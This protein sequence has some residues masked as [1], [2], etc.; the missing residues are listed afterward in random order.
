MKKSQTS[1]NIFPFNHY[2][3]PLQ[4]MESLN[5]NSPISTMKTLPFISPEEQ[6]YMDS[7]K[8]EMKK[9]M[10]SAK[11]EM[12]P[13]F[14]QFPGIQEIINS[15][16]A[17]GRSVASYIAEMQGVTS[18]MNVHENLS[19]SNGF[20]LF[21]PQLEM[22]KA[23]SCQDQFNL[24]TLSQ[25][26]LNL[27]FPINDSE[28]IQ[29]TLSS[30]SPFIIK[31]VPSSALLNL[32]NKNLLVFLTILTIY[33]FG[34]DYPHQYLTLNQLLTPSE[35]KEL[36]NNALNFYHYWGSELNCLSGWCWAG[37]LLIGSCNSV[38]KKAQNKQLDDK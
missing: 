35:L 34:I 29:S 27:D 15:N 28:E 33:L 38:F 17:K 21:H 13:I 10:D 32:N 1:K 18:C 6:E 19:S 2:C 25:Q 9:I 11:A 12:Q 8:A 5:I 20:E 24:L 4:Y 26:D 7:A 36:G 3:S 31:T 30:L 37:M 14:S 16:L 23:I 22:F